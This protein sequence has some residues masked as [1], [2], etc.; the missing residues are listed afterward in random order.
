[1]AH[2]KDVVENLHQ[3]L[4]VFVWNSP[5]LSDHSGLPCGYGHLMLSNRVI[6]RLHQLPLAPPYPSPQLNCIVEVRALLVLNIHISCLG[7]LIRAT[8]AIYNWIGTI[9]RFTYES[10]HP[11]HGNNSGPKGTGRAANVSTQLLQKQIFHSRPSTIS[12]PSQ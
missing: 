9:P 5:T 10:S 3:Q 6:I 2:I 11:Q 8:R 1:M 7:A 4:K 12:G